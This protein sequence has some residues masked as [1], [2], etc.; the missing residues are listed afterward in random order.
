MIT[1]HEE[2]VLLDL[3]GRHDTPT[4]AVRKALGADTCE[5]TLT[6]GD[7]IVIVRDVGAEG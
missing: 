3:L 4:E 5:I 2:T 7:K 6:F 1:A